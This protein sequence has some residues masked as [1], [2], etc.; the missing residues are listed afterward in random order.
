MGP[1]LR[2]ESSMAAFLPNISVMPEETLMI[3]FLITQNSSDRTQNRDGVRS[4][5]FVE[6]FLD[7]MPH[8]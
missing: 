7:T 4:Q 8:G 2:A 1:V 3:S 6:A 5:A